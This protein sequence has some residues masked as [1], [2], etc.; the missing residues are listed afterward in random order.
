MCNPGNG[1]VLLFAL[2]FCSAALLLKNTFQTLVLL[3]CLG[4]YALITSPK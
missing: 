4:T 1:L 2:P 3:V